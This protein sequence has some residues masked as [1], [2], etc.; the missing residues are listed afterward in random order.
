MVCFCKTAMTQLQATAAQL[1]APADAASANANASDGNGNGDGNAPPAAMSGLAAWLA[2][3]GMP[4]APWQPDEAWLQA[5]L[6][7]VSLSPS[8]MA[9]ISA[10]AQLRADVLSNLAI[11]LLVP[12][13]ATGFVRLAATLRERLATQASALPP[14]DASAWSELSATQSA[15]EQVQTANALGIFPAPPPGPPMSMWRTFLS[16]LYP[17]LPMIAASTQLGLDPSGDI[18]AQLSPMLRGLRQVQLPAF[19]PASLLAMARLTTAL[20]AVAR[21]RNSLGIDPLAAGLPAVRDMVAER[22]ADAARTIQSDHGM[23]PAALLALV[24]RLPRPSF[25]PTLMA[26]PAVVQ[27]AMRINA[28]AL[29]AINW[30]VP[31]A[32][33]M[34]ILSVGLPVVAF[35]TQLKAATG[36]SVSSAPCGGGCD[37]A[38]LMRAYS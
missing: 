6:P 21:L 3:F 7:K 24:N 13:Q 16:Q 26:P 30:Q 1:N 14:V 29:A 15:V 34:P 35:T 28:P 8:A 32:S 25:L 36:V 31:P 33:S 38:V 22:A 5:P 11:D 9:T 2:R 17:L 27:A 20:S 18:A 4:A 19:P 23:S 37:A 10:F 12:A